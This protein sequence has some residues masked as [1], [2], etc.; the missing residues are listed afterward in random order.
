MVKIIYIEP[1]GSERPIEVEEGRSVMEGAVANGIRGI[2]AECGGACSCATCHAYIDAAWAETVGAPAGDE[3]EM[4][5]FAYER[6]PGSRLT[7]QI[8]VTDALEGLRVRIPEKQG[9]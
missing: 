7:C 3:A 5:D 9:E 4:L 1:D 2:V 6:A 8:E